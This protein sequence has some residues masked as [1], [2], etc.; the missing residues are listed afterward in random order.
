[1]LQLQT[2]L[3]NKYVVQKEVHTGDCYFFVCT[4]KNISSSIPYKKIV[5]ILQNLLQLSRKMPEEI[6]QVQV[7]R[8][9]TPYAFSN[10]LTG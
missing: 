6:M 9:E 4:T 2:S 8:F 10:C 7:G 1:M 3:Q 5:G